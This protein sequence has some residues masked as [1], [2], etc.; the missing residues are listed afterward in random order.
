MR[1]VTIL[2]CK[3]ILFSFVKAYPHSQPLVKMIGISGF[4]KALTTWDMVNPQIQP[5]LAFPC[6]KMKMKP[7]E[8]EKQ[9]ILEL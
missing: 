8:Q 1:Y 9:I 2:G 3:R 6:G 7:Q 5:Y 4:I